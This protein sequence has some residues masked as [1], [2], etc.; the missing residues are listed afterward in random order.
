MNEYQRQVYLSAF[1][2]ENYMPRWRLALA[3]AA[4]VCDLPVIA[5]EVQLQHLT[6]DEAAKTSIDAAESASTQSV[7]SASVAPLMA[8]VLRTLTQQTFAS[9]KSLSHPPLPPARMPI[10]TERVPAFAL[11]IWR[12]IKDIL[13]I[14]SRNTQLAFPTEALL[15]NILCAVFNIQAPI[16]NEEILRWPLVDNVLVTRTEDD[17]RSALQVWLEVELERRPA[18]Q[19]LFMGRNATQYFL[20]SNMSYDDALWQEIALTN[21]PNPAMVT[22]SLVELLQ[23]PLLKR[24]LWKALQSWQTNR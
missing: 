19:L 8:D 18:R 7:N 23:Q 24:E 9:T 20:P 17:A 22:P 15:N 1:G 3:P 16:G 5:A 11:S 21:S 13:V 6:S 14:D 4:V 12:P 10:G 2:V